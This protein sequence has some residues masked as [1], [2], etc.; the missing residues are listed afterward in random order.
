MILLCLTDVSG[1]EWKPPSTPTNYPWHLSQYLKDRR[2]QLNH[3]LNDLDPV[4]PVSCIYVWGF[5]NSLNICGVSF[6]FV[7]AIQFEH[8]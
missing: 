1:T 7:V 5:I 6:V 4:K 3:V 8:Q 2:N